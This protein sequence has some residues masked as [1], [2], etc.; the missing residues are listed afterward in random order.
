[1]SQK[2]KNKQPE[3]DIKLSYITPLGPIA[4]DTVL[5]YFR[6]GCKKKLFLFGFC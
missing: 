4:V 3:V 2:Q 6:L 1:M 5:K